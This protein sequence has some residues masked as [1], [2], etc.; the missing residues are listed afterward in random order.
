MNIIDTMYNGTIFDGKLINNNNSYIFII[1]DCYYLMGKKII[2]MDMKIKLLHLDNIFTLHL[3]NTTTNF[4]FK[5]NKLY[6]YN[7]LEKLIDN[8]SNLLYTNNGLIFFPK[9]SGINVLHLENKIEK[10][11]N[12]N[13]KII[14][15]NNNI[16]EQK[17]Y[18]IINNFVDFLKN[19]KYSY[20][21]NGI[22]KI[23][24]LKKTLISDVYDIYD[25]NIKIGIALIP[26]LKISHM[27]NELLVDEKLVK[28]NCI[29]SNKF[30]KWIPI[31]PI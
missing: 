12:K 31:A 1:Q 26:N 28:F 13:C 23:L 5:L 6:I 30:K 22:N 15:Q 3:K 2:D 24:L 7:E 4:T 17:S 20:E 21:I 18:N 29:Y 9:K 8:L 16:I 27:C 10:N 14:E 11:D 19:R 25:D